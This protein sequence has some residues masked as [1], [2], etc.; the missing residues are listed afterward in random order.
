MPRLDTITWVRIG[1]GMFVIAAITLSAAQSGRKAESG[2]VS[3][4]VA[5]AARDPLG[6]ELERCN[7]LTP[8]DG[9]DAACERVWAENRRRFLG[10]SA[11]SRS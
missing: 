4:S 7:V 10:A 3:S 6:P 5:E 8:A 11:G 9:R 2:V 1:A